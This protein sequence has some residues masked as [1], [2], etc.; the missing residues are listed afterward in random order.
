V[1]A[2]LW[3]VAIDH[4]MTLRGFAIARYGLMAAGRKAKVYFISLDYPVV[5]H[6]IKSALFFHYD[7]VSNSFFGHL[8][9]GWNTARND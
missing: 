7:N 8:G 1:K 3:V 9:H 4:I 5:M 2:A 6:Q